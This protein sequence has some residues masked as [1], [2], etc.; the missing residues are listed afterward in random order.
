[1]AIPGD[2][3]GSHNCEG[4]T[5]GFWWV[6]AMDATE[7]YRKRITLPVTENYPAP[8]VSSIKMKKPF[9]L[10]VALKVGSLNH[11]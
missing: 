6:E 8:K 5:A 1:M 7:H 4:G 9:S 10:A 3:F 11:Q 2:V